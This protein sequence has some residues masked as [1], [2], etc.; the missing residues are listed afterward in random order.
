MAAE[1]SIL[2]PLV[3][4]FMCFLCAWILCRLLFFEEGG[5]CDL[6]SEMNND[7]IKFLNTSGSIIDLNL[8]LVTPIHEQF[9]FFMLLSFPE[10]SVMHFLLPWILVVTVIFFSCLTSQSDLILLH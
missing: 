4:I 8:S 10:L 3:Y 6:N 5:G 2:F 9:H 1:S 7:V